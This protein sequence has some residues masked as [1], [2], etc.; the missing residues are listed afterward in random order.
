M[1]ERPKPMAAVLRKLTKAVAN[2]L[3]APLATR[4]STTGEREFR[5]SESNMEYRDPLRRLKPFVISTTRENGQSREQ[6]LRI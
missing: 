1:E 4:F 5:G 2:A 3:E 6:T